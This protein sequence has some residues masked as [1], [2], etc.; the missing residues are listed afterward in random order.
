MPAQE[1]RDEVYF[2]AK[3]EK[4][5]CFSEEE[6]HSRLTRIR[7][8]MRESDIDC[9]YLTSPESLF[10]VS[11]YRTEWYQAESPMQWPPC[12]GIAV[13]RDHDRF[14]L[15]DGEREAILT[16]I[17]TVSKDTRFFPRHSY[18]DGIQ[19]VAEE[20]KKEGWLAGKLGLEFWSHRPNRAVSERFQRAFENAGGSVVDGSLILREVRWI[21][22]PVEVECLEKAAEIAEVGVRTAREVLRPGVTELEVYGEIV[23]AMSAAG[24]ENPGITM[25][26]LSG[27]K[28]NSPHALASR[29]EM[30]AGEIVAVDVSGVYNRY[31]INMARTFSLG[32]PSKEA[33]D[34][35]RRAAGS[36]DV[37]RGLLRPNL[38][39]R[40]LN[41]A[42]LEYYQKEGIWE[43]RGWI[44]GYE[45]GIAFPPD[46]VGHFV[47]DP[48]SD[49]NQDRMFEP[50]TAVNYENQFFLPDHSGLFL[51]IVS[52]LFK[53][54][55]ATLLSNQPYDLIEI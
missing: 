27:S 44:G 40:E 41:E 1:Y 6:Y 24:G 32:E 19:F 10:Y 12:S 49:V 11:G 17:Y 18:R 4:E 55:S 36:T 8:H 38:P 29:R 21:K 35:A 28:A 46:W 13:H 42:V 48:L 33:A 9:L 30:A 16:R 5:I 15:F 25:P 7:E 45:M 54:D 52:L 22:S 26:V 47:Y 53:E 39:V 50:G 14:I 3:P 34:I 2:E 51:M 43:R 20:L 23:R 31:H 37:I